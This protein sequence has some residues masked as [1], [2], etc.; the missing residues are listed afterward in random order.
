MTLV[1]CQKTQAYMKPS[2]SQQ[3]AVFMDTSAIALLIYTYSK[4]CV[5][6]HNQKKKKEI[7]MTKFMVA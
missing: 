6:I 7:L 3:G 2:I 4:T 5:Q 1:S